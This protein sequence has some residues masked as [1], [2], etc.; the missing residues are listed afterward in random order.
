MGFFSIHIILKDYT[1]SL[2]FSVNGFA[3]HIK[4]KSGD[5]DLFINQVATKTNIR[6]CFSSN[7]FTE[8]KP[9]TS[10]KNWILQKRRHV[11]TASHYKTIHKFLF[12]LDTS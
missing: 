7:S 12:Y 5:D 1:K 2:F 10:F 6:N 8:S 9:K 4:I 11:S 3:D